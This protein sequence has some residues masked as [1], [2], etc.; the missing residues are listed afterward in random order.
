MVGRVRWREKEGS[1]MQTY[2]C[3]F[4][5]RMVEREGAHRI[6][7]WHAKRETRREGE[8]NQSANRDA[9]GTAVGLGRLRL[10]LRTGAR[11]DAQAAALS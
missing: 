4:E 6:I 8:H 5:E 11:Y 3:A 2:T 1:I 7:E 9:R 10:V